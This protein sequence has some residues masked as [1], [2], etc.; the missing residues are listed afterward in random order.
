MSMGQYGSGTRRPSI[1]NR[2]RFWAFL[3]VKIFVV[4]AIVYFTS[5]DL[6]SSLV[7]PYSP[8][9]G[10]VQFTS[11]LVF[12]LLGLRWAF[13]DQQKRCRVCLSRMARPVAIGELSKAF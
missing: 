1:V 9:S 8:F 4:L 3:M 10:S 5:V 11:S 6:D 12:G 7:Q 13:R 2:I